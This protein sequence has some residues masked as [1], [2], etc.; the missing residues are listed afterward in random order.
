[1][2]LQKLF[3]ANSIRHFN[4]NFSN[5]LIRIL[6]YLH[7]CNDITFF[8]LFILSV[9]SCCYVVDFMYTLSFYLYNV[10]CHSVIRISSLVAL[11]LTDIS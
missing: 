9:I 7:Y 4:M 1:M 11:V 10:N 2:T 6:L 3:D 5:F 8:F